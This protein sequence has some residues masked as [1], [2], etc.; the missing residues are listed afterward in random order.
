MKALVLRAIPVVVAAGFILAVALWLSATPAYDVAPRLPEKGRGSPKPLA[1]S[2]P[3]EF[4]QGEGK[5]ADSFAAWPQFRGPDRSAVAPASPPLAR[6]WPAGGPPVLWTVKMGLGY[7]APAV[8][9]GRVY[10]LDYDKSKQADALRCLSL[11]DGKEIW[12]RWYKIP[13][14][15]DHGMSRTVPAVTYQ[16]VVTLG[17]KCHVMCCDANSGEFRWGIDLVREYGTTVPKWYAGQCP[18]IDMGKAILA[19]AGKD[20]LMMA[21]ECQADENA[22]GQPKIAW[23][24]PNPHGWKMTHSSIV[25]M[26]YADRR[27]YIYCASGGVV[28]VAAGDGDTWKAGSLLWETADWQVRFANAPSPVVIGNGHVLL[29]GGYGAG[30]MMIR[31]VE[32]DDGGLGVVTVWRLEKS[33]EFGSEQQTPIFYD[34]HVYGILPKEA[35]ALAEQLI[36][37][38]LRGRHVWA[39]GR[40]YRFG[41]GSYAIADGLLLAMN[42]NGVLTMAEASAE[43]FKPLA[44]AE[45]LAGGHET[46]APM[47]IADGRL[48]VRDLEKM[49]CLDVRDKKD[50]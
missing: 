42:D 32:Q 23:T 25:P 37:M 28:G 30:S 19:P 38:D 39:S 7:A 49:V 24:T 5:P 16:D 46:W 26:E 3:G 11:D 2:W 47:A 33:R 15:S 48:L 40:D 35:G 34:G 45:V 14:D 36:C 22:P 27:M 10:L 21:V 4:R 18:L 8:S 1:V 41:L 12:R 31:V 43:A 50:E 44:R 29:T 6:S 17:P 13:V 9:G 20:V